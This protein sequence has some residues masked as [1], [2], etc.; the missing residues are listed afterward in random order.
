ML[1]K[2]IFV[3]LVFCGVLIFALS[4][5]HRVPPALPSHGRVLT[6]EQGSTAMHE[7]QQTTALSSVT[8]A[9]PQEKGN[10]AGAVANRIKEIPVTRTDLQ[11]APVGEFQG[12]PIEDSRFIKKYTLEP[13]KLNSVP[14]LSHP[15]VMTEENAKLMLRQPPMPAMSNPVN[16]APPAG[17]MPSPQ[18]MTRERK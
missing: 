9:I 17:W 16:A 4:Q 14:Q 5:L 10:A 12:A 7:Q 6:P 11:K 8:E 1:N 3:L 13:G 18:N 15:M 2:F